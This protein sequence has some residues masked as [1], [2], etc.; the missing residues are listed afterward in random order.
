VWKA[1]GPTADAAALKDTALYVASGNEHVGPL[2]DGH[3]SP[4]D[5]SGDGE[6]A[7]AAE[8]AAFVQRLAELKIPVTVHAYWNGTRNAPYFQRDLRR[9]L[10]F[11]LKALGV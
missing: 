8:S 5:E 4:Y 3:V 6:R 7:G 9:S 2:D 1:H 11:I 10:P